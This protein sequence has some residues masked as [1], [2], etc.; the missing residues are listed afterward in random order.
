MVTLIINY[1]KSFHPRLDFD[2]FL[3]GTLW[4]ITIAIILI[5]LSHC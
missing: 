3:G 4:L 5:A 2:G 1:I